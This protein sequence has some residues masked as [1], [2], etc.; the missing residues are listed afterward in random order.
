MLDH[1]KHIIKAFIIK[2]ND[3]ASNNNFGV[4][5]N[6]HNYVA[7]PVSGARCEVLRRN[8]TK[9]F[10]GCLSA[11]QLFGFSSILLRKVKTKILIASLGADVENMNK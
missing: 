10:E 11:D 7:T 3:D 6:A 4:C 1:N 8:N 5:F 2:D 9:A